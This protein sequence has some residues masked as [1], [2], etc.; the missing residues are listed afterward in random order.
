MR[1][2]QHDDQS[3]RRGLYGS[4]HE[5]RLSVLDEATCTFLGDD[6]CASSYEVDTVLFDSDSFGDFDDTLRNASVY[7]E[8]EYALNPRWTV[9]A[10]FRAFD[11]HME[12]EILPSKTTMRTESSEAWHPV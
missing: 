10:G 2:Q 12:S 7:G 11:L 4:R 8:L 1:L 3:R 9:L 5:I 6:P